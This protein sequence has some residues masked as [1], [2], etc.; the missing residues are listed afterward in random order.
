[1]EIWIDLTRVKW[2]TENRAGGC[3]GVSHVSEQRLSE[4]LT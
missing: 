3:T 4:P 1:M 2:V